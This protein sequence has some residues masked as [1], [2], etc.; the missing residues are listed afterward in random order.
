MPKK[1]LLEYDDENPYY[2]LGISSSVKDYQMVFD[3]N[4]HLDLKFSHAEAFRF[5]HKGQEFVYSFYLYID[6]ENLINY[7]LIS[8]RDSTNHLVPS[9]KQLDFFIIVEGEIIEEEVKTLAQRI[10]ALP[11]VLFATPLE[12]D[13]FEKIKGLRY[14]F[15]MHLEKVLKV[16]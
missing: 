16:L 1:L 15:D 9:Y 8:N 3:L 13:N 10:K 5:S 4:K 11:R 6:H 12:A 2:Y 7:Y 14:E